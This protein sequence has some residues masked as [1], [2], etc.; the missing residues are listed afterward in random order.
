MGEAAAEAGEDEAAEVERL[1][2]FMLKL[3][4]EPVMIM[5]VL[6]VEHFLRMNE[7]EEMDDGKFM[8]MAEETMVGDVVSGGR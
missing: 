7:G 6:E 8:P 4:G 3:V 1:D 5:V 2:K